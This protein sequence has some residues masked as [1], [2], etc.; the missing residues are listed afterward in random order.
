MNTPK[1]RIVSILI[2]SDEMIAYQFFKH[3][4]DFSSRLISQIVD[5]A[6]SRVDLRQKVEHNNGTR[7]NNQI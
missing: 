3:K 7:L 1:I 6:Q 4:F 2:H 5:V